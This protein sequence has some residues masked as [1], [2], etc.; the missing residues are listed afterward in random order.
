[1]VVSTPFLRVL[2]ASAAAALLAG[3]SGAGSSAPA[4]LTGNGAT[5]AHARSGFS[6]S[7]AQTARS[8]GLI[9][10]ADYTNSAIHIY[11]GR[12]RN[13]KEI[14]LIT[15]DPVIEYLNVDRWHNLYVVEFVA[16]KVL[17]YP[18]GATQPSLT[19]SVQPAGNFP[20][21]VAISHD[22]EV[23]VGQFQTTGIEF[24]H[25]GASTP[26][27]TVAPPAGFG[28]PGFC[29]YDA[30]GNL[31]VIGSRA[32]GASQIGEIVG[33]SKGTKIVNLGVNTGITN[34]KGLQIDTQGNIAVVGDDGTLNLYKARSNTLLSSSQLLYPP[35][36]GPDPN[37]GFSLMR[38]GK[39]LYVASAFLNAQNLGQALQ[40]AYPA[41]GSV[42]NTITVQIPPSGQ[43]QTSVT[44]VAVDPPEQP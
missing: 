17:V 24:F 22:G 32:S 21:A 39:Y 10:V 18:R 33:G 8:A 9:Y 41:G 29:A 19:L 11:P 43:G 7:F 42:R 26:F 28:S 1:M 44:G 31:Y 4:A 23:A 30:S 35:D 34:A 27:K 5:Q 36:N 2:S 3:C 25:K 6:A 12:G 15:G 40:Y 38:A 13:Q 14:G 16:G 37:G 20:N